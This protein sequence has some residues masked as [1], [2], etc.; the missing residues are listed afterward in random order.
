MGEMTRENAAEI[1]EWM[2]NL[3]TAIDR[4]MEYQRNG[5][6]V[7]VN[8]NGHKL[9]SCDITVD[10]AYKEVIGMTKEESI[11]AREESRRAW[12]LKRKEEKERA[13]RK[14]PE[15]I[16]KGEKSIF[17][18]RFE[19]WKYYVETSARQG[20]YA[21]SDIEDTLEIMDMINSGASFED[22][23]KKLEEQ[24]YSGNS[25]GIVTKNLLH[26]AKN[27]P[28]F[29]ETVVLKGKPDPESKQVLDEI[30][31]EN[32]TFAKRLEKGDTESLLAQLKGIKK[33][34]LSERKF[35][36]QVL[37]IIK[38]MRENHEITKDEEAFV[39]TL[40]EIGCLDSEEW[41][42]AKQVAGEQVQ[43]AENVGEGIRSANIGTAVNLISNYMHSPSFMQSYMND[44]IWDEEWI[45]NSIEL[46]RGKLKIPYYQVAQQAL[47]N[48][49]GLSEEQAQKIVLE[50]SFQEVDSQVYAKGSM[51]YAIDGMCKFMSE[52][53][54]L[55]VLEGDK[56]ELADFVYNG[57]KSGIAEELES[58]SAFA[59]GTRGLPGKEYPKTKS[60]LDNMIMD[61][62]FAV[63]DGWVQDNVK[64]FNAREKKHQHMPS[65]LIGWKEVKADLLFVR[66]IFEAA[67]VQVNE[68]ELEQV[69]NGR[70]K[71]FF[72]DHGIQ[73][74]R[75]LSDSITQGEE[76]YPALEGY[77]EILTT[78]NDP[79][80]V[81]E[82]IIPAIE[83]QGI[84]N[85]EEIRKNIVSQ[86]ISNPVPE[87]VARLSDEE[88]AKVEQS[89]GQEV[90]TLTA[91]RDELHQKNSIVQR[92]MALA[93]RRRTIKKEISIE[94][95]RK[96]ENIHE[97]DD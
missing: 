50:Q 29:Y 75:N 65:E 95:Q 37:S 94:E 49:N 90:S 2:G 5:R 72:L 32:E 45:Q 67:G 19:D 34:E 48:W 93:N 71:E 70:V 41:M 61:T 27:G 53:M 36:E 30:R 43:T 16:K 24:G 84:G 82:K 28:D 47:M 85:I 52:K 39:N 76:F 14:I 10:G 74:A 60:L 62:L 51:D 59:N 11:K 80:Y 97:F 81:D 46:E 6:S 35:Y 22:I 69:Y 9:Y 56:K 91:Q 38:D 33:E 15:W 13:E 58:M 12:E 31:K 57:G 83:Q 40:R 87:D 78:I 20:M 21:G 8:F 64:K 25:Y 42:A 73:T 96:S 26:F 23:E 79:D 66:P 1:D 7:Y 63:H 55:L 86:I 54:D 17:E 89:I 68:E 4:L 18:E 44:R 88:K 92:I 77:G 3:D